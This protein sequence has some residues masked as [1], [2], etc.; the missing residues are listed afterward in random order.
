MD[1]ISLLISLVSGIVGGNV[2]GTAMKEKS[3]GTIGNSIAGLLGG[4]I[5]TFILHVLGVLNTAAAGTGI[6]GLGNLG[7]ILTNV[8]GSGVGGAVL[9]VIISLIKDY[10]QKKA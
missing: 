4:G 7:S 8:G 5:G 3:L 9:V 1:I 10:L 2:A 6:A